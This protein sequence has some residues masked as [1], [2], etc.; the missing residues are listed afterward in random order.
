MAIVLA[1]VL[2]LNIRLIDAFRRRTCGCG[3]AKRCP[4]VE[5]ALT[6]RERQRR[7][8]DVAPAAPPQAN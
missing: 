6:S 7:P 3:L 8:T 4:A 1:A 2:Y 5:H